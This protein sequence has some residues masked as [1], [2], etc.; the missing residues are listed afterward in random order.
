[1]ATVNTPS[2]P[3][4]IP[5][6]SVL[7]SA[8]G[9][10]ILFGEHAVV[11]KKT[12]I[13][14]SLGLR[15]Y[16]YVGQRDDGL[17]HVILPDINVDKQWSVK[18]IPF[19]EHCRTDTT[20]PMEMSSDILARLK[21]LIGSVDGVHQ[22]QAIMAALYLM[23]ILGSA[24]SSF[25]GLTLCARSF[26][27]VGAGLG[28]SACYSVVLSAAILISFG[29]IPYDFTTSIHQ[30]DYL[31]TINHY[32]YRS[33]QVIHGNPSGVD[34]AIA[35]YGGAKSFVKGQGFSTI[36]EFHATR[37]LL[38][39]T[40]VPRST[41]VLVAGVATRRNKYPAV[42]DPILESIDAISLECKSIMH[43]FGANEEHL[44][45]LEEG[46]ED[47]IDINHCLLNSLGVSH[48]SLE[49]VRMV[50]ARHGFKAKLTGAGG[51]GCAFTLLRS[52]TEQSTIDTIL[53]ELATHGFDGFQTFVGGKGVKAIEMQDKDEHWLIE[54]TREILESFSKQ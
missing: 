32:A 25:K 53:Q 49:M 38:I 24:S 28:S 33:E 41:N 48:P 2:T 22:E 3:S 39:N 11:Y 26:V 21:T 10:V 7:L 1:M 36:D 34:N 6:K 45:K 44:S 30:S 29:Y 13:A 27:P 20:H 31:E 16:L 46:L 17:C 52:A 54:S 40:K 19:V 15:C 18:D 4:F 51:G 42:V 43:A 9:K 47:L 8:P 50:T 23:T 37:L 12:A 35:T 5:P 14:A